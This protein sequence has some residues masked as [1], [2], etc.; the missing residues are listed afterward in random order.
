MKNTRLSKGFTLI[1]L[2][3][4]ITII[5]I[6]AV[7]LLPSVLGAPARARDA[8]RKADLNNIIAAIETY[9][10]DHQHYPADDGVAVDALTDGGAG[11]DVLS[12]Y[13][14]G[15]KAPVDP[16]GKGPDGAAGTYMYNVGTGNPS[17]YVVGSYVEQAGDGNV[18]WASVTGGGFGSGD[19]DAAANTAINTAL[20][21]CKP[22]NSGASADCDAYVIVK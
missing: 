5:G 15:G 6:L 17:S 11:T 21:D 20:K 2:L 7:A 10:S 3:I 19:I 4:V 22:I 13:F 18:V 9:N 12:S 16:Q 1:E 14:Q 8:A